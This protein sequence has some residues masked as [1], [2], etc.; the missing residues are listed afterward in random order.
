MTFKQAWPIAVMQEVEYGEWRKEEERASAFIQWKGTDV[1]LDLSCECGYSSHLDAEF[2]Y[3]IKCPKCK[4]E[5]VMPADIVLLKKSDVSPTMY[6]HESKVCEGD[7]P[8]Q[9]ED[10]VWPTVCSGC[11]KDPAEGEAYLEWLD[12]GEY[13]EK[14]YCY[15]GAGN[16]SCWET[17]RIENP[18]A[19]WSRE[20]PK[21]PSV[22]RLR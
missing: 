2:A 15:A 20:E 16:P 11:G 14:R 9:D 5:Y 22:E 3:A 10:F 6:D 8:E 21:I 19:G 12:D 18:S 17:A 7:R 1:C 4:T 13:I